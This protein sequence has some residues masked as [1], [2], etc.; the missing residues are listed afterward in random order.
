MKM[1]ILIKEY[2]EKLSENTNDYSCLLFALQIPSICSR[3]EFP[4]T[5]KNKKE[6]EDKKL[7]KANGKVWDS[8]IYKYWLQSHIGY[9]L[10]FFYTI[11]PIDTFCNNIY[12]LRCQITHEGVLMS[13]NNKVFFTENNEFM[14]IDDIVFLQLSSFC[15]AMF[16]AAESIITNPD[17]DLDITMFK[18]IPI[19]TNIFYKIEKD[20]RDTY[21]K[22]WENYSKEDKELNHIFDLISYK[23]IL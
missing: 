2:R 9:F 18:D 4:L 5:E 7:Y 12:E 16:N 11:M 1:S 23:K 8:N 22:F 10:Q 6:Y 21:H 17:K 13:S 15:E 14:G 20:T 19:P 3:I